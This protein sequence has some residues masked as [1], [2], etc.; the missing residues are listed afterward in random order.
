MSLIVKRIQEPSKRDR[1]H[2]LGVNADTYPDNATT[3]TN[4][5]KAK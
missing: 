1:N 4:I 3:T 2:T 5:T